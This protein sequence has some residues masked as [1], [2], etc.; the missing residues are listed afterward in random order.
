MSW[1]LEGLGTRRSLA[2]IRVGSGRTRIRYPREAARLKAQDRSG[3]AP[4][5]SERSRLA[6]GLAEWSCAR[7]T[8]QCSVA[9]RPPEASTCCRPTRGHF[10]PAQHPSSGTWRAFSFRQQPANAAAAPAVI[11]PCHR[12]KP[13][14]RCISRVHCPTGSPPSRSVHDRPDTGEL[15][16]C[17]PPVC[18]C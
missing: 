9:P 8:R 6:R 17:A 11:A 3:N 14:S 4:G 7:P 10:G 15:A 16:L 18:M 1:V 13:A 5:S 2:R 12:S